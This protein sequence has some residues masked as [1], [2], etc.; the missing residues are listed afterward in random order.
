MIQSRIYTICDD[1]GRELKIVIKSAYEIQKA[2]R[3]KGEVIKK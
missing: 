1:N 3:F 2:N